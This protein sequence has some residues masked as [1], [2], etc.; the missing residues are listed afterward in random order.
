MK[1][2]IKHEKNC[3]EKKSLEQLE[4]FADIHASRK[5]ASACEIGPKIDMVFWAQQR[6]NPRAAGRK[7]L[8]RAELVGD[9]N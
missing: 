4:R 5:A 8:V 9:T 1:V 3:P 2:S 6:A 7:S